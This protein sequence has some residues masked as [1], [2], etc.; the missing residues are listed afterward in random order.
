ML[1]VDLLAAQSP[2]SGVQAPPLMLQLTALDNGR[3]QV[4]WHPTSDTVWAQLLKAG[5]SVT[6]Q[7]VDATGRNVGSA[8][9]LAARILPRDSTWFARRAATEQGVLV[10]IQALLFDTAYQ[11][12]DP[13]GLDANAQRFNYIGYEVFRDQKVASAVGLGLTDSTTQTTSSYRYTVTGLGS[14]RPSASAMIQP[15]EFGLERNTWDYEQDWQL[16]GNRSLSDMLAESQPTEQ[17]YV[18]AIARGYGDSVVV[19]WAPTTP[20]LWRAALTNGYSVS[21]I[22]AGDTAF[23][24]LQTVLPLP[25]R[26]LTRELIARDSAVLIAAG[27]IYRKANNDKEL[28]LYDRA[29]IEK[30]SFGFALFAADQSQAAAQVLGLRYVDKSVRRDSTYRYVIRPLPAKGDS[31]SIGRSGFVAVTNTYV[32]TAAPVG[33]LAKPLDGAVEL[34]WD[35]PENETSFSA[36]DVERSS[37]TSN[38]F[39]KL[40]QRPIVFV[41]DERLPLASFSYLDTAVTNGTSY[42]YRLTGFDSFG[43]RSEAAAAT[44]TPVDQTPP[45]GVSLYRATY[46]AN[47]GTIAVGW[48]PFAIEPDLVHRTLVLAEAADGP[49]VEVSPQL[50]PRDTSFRY[51][52][53]SAEGDRDRGY[54]F[55][56]RSVDASGN[57]GQSTV[58]QAIVPDL[59][60]PAAPINLVGT[61]DTNSFVTVTWS[62]S[63]SKDVEGYWLYWGN[64]PSDEMAAVN[65]QLIRDTTFTYYIDKKALQREIYYCVRAEDDVANRGFVSDVVRVK[66]LDVI[67]PTAPVLLGASESAEGGIQ[68]EWIAGDDEELA[69][70][71]IYRNSPDGTALASADSMSA[72]NAALALGASNPV[73]IYLSKVLPTENSYTDLPEGAVG[74]AFRY[75]V[76]AEDASGNIS[77]PSVERGDRIRFPAA[78]IVPKDVLVQKVAGAAVPAVNL[79]WKLPVPSALYV[80]EPRVFEIYRS[81]GSDSPELFTTVKGDVLMYAGTDLQ[82]GTLYNYAVR[83]RYDN[84]WTGDLSEIVSVLTE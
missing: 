69:A 50:A 26:T 10:P 37:G 28:S 75:H 49:W 46:D 31:T 38:A 45:R 61:V 71:H 84:G 32:P 62:P 8:T 72:G 82:P 64:R 25:E 4:A 58:R 20:K 36:Y 52:M 83:V 79:S 42:R 3:V 81:T 17:E 13:D 63:A 76:L 80:N 73:W 68:L 6:R 33:L 41:E 43:E 34:V 77:E 59:I 51:V 56:V 19:R 74:E 48:K 66:R 67:P 30:N 14:T 65:A 39:V 57:V 2:V 70:Y 23:V 24:V 5:Y 9:T 55:A 35:K 47:A 53:P 29:S 16:P 60:A 22:A 21:R 78:V 44:A 15:G 27:I 18:A 7:A 1:L 40:N 12:S 54:F 11:V